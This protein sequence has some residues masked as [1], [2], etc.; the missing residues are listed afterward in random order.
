MAAMEGAGRDAGGDSAGPSSSPTRL[1]HGRTRSAAARAIFASSS[2]Q[3]NNNTLFGALTSLTGNT[4]RIPPPNTPTATTDLEAQRR[5]TLLEG[6]HSSPFGIGDDEDEQEDQPLQTTTH[7]TR[8]RYKS[9]DST[10]ESDKIIGGDGYDGDDGLEEED[11]DE[12]EEAQ[13]ASMAEPGSEYT[14]LLQL[15]PVPSNKPTNRG[16]TSS[17][18]HKPAGRLRPPDGEDDDTK[19]QASASS[20]PA[21]AAAPVVVIPF[22]PISRGEKTWMWIVTGL[23]SVLIVVAMLISEDVID[24]PGDG[25]GRD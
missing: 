10:Q 23:V 11:I 20:T 21:T 15:K 12:D 7:S 16:A 18:S 6:D 22:E 4:R 17:S 3:P 1:L 25:I 8:S 19:H 2:S 13:Y 5:T 24:W 14:S 9:S